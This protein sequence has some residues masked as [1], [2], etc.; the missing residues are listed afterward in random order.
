MQLS[1]FRFWSISVSV[2]PH[3]TTI[4]IFKN[5]IASALFTLAFVNITEANYGLAPVTT[6][7]NSQTGA[8]PFRRNILDLQNDAPAW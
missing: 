5:V 1:S 3:A 6:G 4:M 2:S 7:I 8:R